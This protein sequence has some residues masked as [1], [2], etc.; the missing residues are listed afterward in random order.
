EKR[1]PRHGHTSCCI[2]W[3]GHCLVD[4]CSIPRFT[5]REWLASASLFGAQYRW[6]CCGTARGYVFRLERVQ[7]WDVGYRLGRGG[8]HHDPAGRKLAYPP[9]IPGCTLSKN[10]VYFA[11]QKIQ[12]DEFKFKERNHVNIDLS[13]NEESEL[14]T[15]SLGEKIET[16]IEKLPPTEV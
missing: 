1:E 4:G 16:I 9:L 11:G 10:S 14:Q 8:K 2:V 13:K 7:V 6:L 3:S 12:I 5:W 15:E